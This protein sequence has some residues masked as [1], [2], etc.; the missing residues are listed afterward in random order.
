MGGWLRSRRPRFAVQVASYV[1]LSAIFPGEPSDFDSFRA[2]LRTLSRTD[3]IFW[4]ARLNLIVSNPQNT[5]EGSKQRYCIEHF[6]DAQEIERGKQFEKEHPGARPF[7]REQLLELMRWACLL[8]DDLPNDGNSFQDPEMRRRFL[9]AALMASELRGDRVFAGGLPMSGDLRADRLRSIVSLRDAV[10]ERSADIMQVLVRG[11]AIYRNTFPTRYPDAEA[12]FLHATGITLKQYLDCVG[13]VDVFFGSI[14][15]QAVTPENWGGIRIGPVREQIPE[16]MREPFDRYVA[17]ESQTADEL[18]AAV[19]S[20]RRPDGVDGTEPFD[21]RAL[22]E[23]PLLR[24]PDG[25]A[26]ILDLAFFAE[27]AAVGPRFTLASWLTRRGE[28]KQAERVSQAFGDAFEDYVTG[29]LRAMY[30]E[31][32]LLSSRL[33]CDARGR[34]KDGSDAQIADACLNDVRRA[35]TFECKGGFIPEGVTRDAETY[36]RSMREKYGGKKGVGQLGRWIKDIATG[37]VTPI[38]QDWS[39]VEQVYPVLIAYDDRIDRPG[40]AELLAE[41]FAKTLEPDQVLPGATM[42][43][44]RF[45]VAPPTVMPL[46][47]LEMLESSV[48]NFGL[49]DLLQDYADARQ[50][51]GHL[52][53]H[54]YLAYTEG[55]K[56]RLS[57]SAFAARALTLLEG[58]RERMFPHMPIPGGS[59]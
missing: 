16:G 18:R 32:P 51:G 5:D 37:T 28:T 50:R 4:C 56:Y 30:P 11:D 23:R 10:C 13:T 15:P 35:V 42:R 46:D 55:K 9:K 36:Q 41:E 54:D 52:S 29:I 39:R 3:T 45:T 38:G 44:G 25:R 27:K 24:T 20:D 48:R 19:W 26:L 7:F 34:L 40:H 21:S 43:K 49:A 22:R 57:R 12:Q 2:L 33:I 1:P 8:A 14:H 58:V 47:I 31:S 53:L 6:C 17:L 59:E